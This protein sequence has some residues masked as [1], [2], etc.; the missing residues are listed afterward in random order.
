MSKRKITISDLI[1][2]YFF[3]NPGKDLPHGP[4]VDYVEERYKELYGK[5]RE[6]P[7]DRYADYIN[8]D[9]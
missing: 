9:Y 5:S 7:G 2:E 3:K 4:V 1:M 6:T 8:K